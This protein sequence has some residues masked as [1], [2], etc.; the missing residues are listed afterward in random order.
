MEKK[1]VPY[2]IYLPAEYIEKLKKLAKE[3]KASS[4]IRDSILMLID[5]KSAFDAGYKKGIKD[6][7]K[8]IDNNKECEI[9]HIKGKYLNDIL[10][11]QIMLLE[12]K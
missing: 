10:I 7:I 9:I 8:V 6:A 2:S 4:L 11:D 5:E 1:L 3:R 12:S